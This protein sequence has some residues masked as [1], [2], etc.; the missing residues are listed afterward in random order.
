MVL[1]LWIPSTVPLLARSAR[2]N[3]RIDNH[4]NYAL[5]VQGLAGRMQEWRAERGA[6]G[7]NPPQT[8]SQSKG[9][10]SLQSSSNLA[11]N[12]TPL[13]RGAHPAS[14]SSHFADCLHTRGTITKQLHPL[15][16][17]SCGSKTRFRCMGTTSVNDAWDFGGSGDET[18]CSR[19]SAVGMATGYG[20]D[21]IGAGRAFSTSS[22]PV[23]GPTHPPIQWMP[24]AISPGVKRP[25]REGDHSPPTSA[26]VNRTCIYTSIPTYAFM[27]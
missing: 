12:P 26:K 24:E 2:W 16:A 19:D 9:L 27:V 6:Q 5:T 15:T 17:I 7:S 3:H 23:L 4:S 1:H 13:T 25:E 10:F 21:N 22:R 20:P 14:Y 8:Q 18:A 11:Q